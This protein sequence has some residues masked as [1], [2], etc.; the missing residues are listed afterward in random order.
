MFISGAQCDFDKQ[1]V[2]DNQFAFC[3]E[4]NAVDGG[5]ATNK[6][7]SFPCDIT[8]PDMDINSIY[9]HNVFTVEI[10]SNK[11]SAH[12]HEHKHEHC[13]KCISLQ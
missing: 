8:T 9:E 4:G 5:F 3:G 7:M 10:T 11:Q 2:W 12:V 6:S 13:C 1:S